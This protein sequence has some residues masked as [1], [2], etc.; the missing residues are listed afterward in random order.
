MGQ[1]TPPPQHAYKRPMC[2]HQSLA[3]MQAC[4]QHFRAHACTMHGARRKSLY[5]PQRRHQPGLGLQL[6]RRQLRNHP[7]LAL[8]AALSMQ[9]RSCKDMRFQS[10]NLGGEI[11]PRRCT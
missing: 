4:V 11:Q 3:R 9:L 7:R 5:A 2:M 10:T 1:H 8:L 6:Q